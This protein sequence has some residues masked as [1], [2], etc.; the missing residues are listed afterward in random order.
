MNKPYYLDT[1]GAFVIEEYQQAKLFAD[2]FPGVSG[3]YG[4]PMWAFFVNRG[5]AVSSFG[6]ESKDKA[7]LEF[8]PANKAYRSTSIEGFRT[9]LKINDGKGQKYYEPF[10]NAFASRYKVRQRM[11]ITSYD[12]TIEE[13]NTTLGLKVTV[14]YFTM[15]Q[16]PFAGLV[17]RVI[18]E[19]TGPK[20]LDIHC[21]DG[22]PVINPYGLKD[23]LSKNMSRTVE[24]W[25]T[26]HHTDNKAPF[27]QLKVEV[28]DTPQV[29]PIKEGNFYF[30]FDSNSRKQL[31]MIV[32]ASCVFGQASDFLVPENFLRQN[33]FSIPAHQQTANRTPSAM[34]VNRFTL[35]KGKKHGFTALAGFAH[36]LAELKRV[37]KKSTADG[38]IEKKAGLNRQIIDS[39]KDHCFTHSASNE[40][41]Q[42]CGQTFLD[43]I[44]R[45][46]LPISLQNAEGAVS[47]N[48]Y[49]RKHGDL[50]R[51][52]NFF[53]LSPT[54]LSQGN[55]NYRDVNQNRRND[56][57]FNKDV[58]DSSIVNFLNLIQADGYNPLIV[59]GTHFAIKNE[60][61][62]KP[63]FGEFGVE[64]GAERLES[65]LKKGF[66]P[67]E[68]LETVLREVPIKGKP[69]DFLTKI[70]GACT[71]D[72]SA[73][74]GEGFWSDH[75][76]YNLDL[77]NSYLGLY[78]EKLKG[79]FFE[80]RVFT[81]FLNDLY[82][83]PRD[84]RY[85]LTPSGV[86]Q[87]HSL[88]EHDKDVQAKAKGYKLRSNN[89]AGDVYTTSLLVK[90]TCLLANKAATLDPSGIGIEM[91]ANK[92]NW[93]DA[94]NGLPGL[95]GS[96]ISETFEVKRFAVF[97]K[98]SLEQLKIDDQTAVL[99]FEE[100]A[101]FIQGLLHVLSTENDPFK[102]WQKSNDLKEHYRQTVRYGI[103]GQEKPISVAEI[104]KLM[105]SIIEK[106]DAGILKARHGNGLFATYFYH[107][108]TVYD[109]LDKSHYGRH[110]VRANA[111]KRHDLPLFLEG[112][113]H[114]L[115][116][117]KVP[118]EAKALYKKV[119]SSPLFDQ[120]LGMYRVNADLSRE[121]DEI[122]RT[123]IF[124]AGW[125]ENGSVW[126]HMEYKY[127]LE[128]L[129]CGLS[130]EFYSEIHQAMVPF[131]DP[132]KYGRSIL[133]NS[134]FIVS[135]A[136]E[137]KDLHGRGFVA[138]L[139]G[140][141]AEF[142]HIWLV[143]NMGLEPFALDK[144][145]RLTLTFDPILPSWL[146]TERPSGPFKARTYSFKLFVNIM[147]TYHNPLLKD[148][149]GP[150]GARAHKIILSY[151]GRKS[152]EITG[153]V[154]G[155][156]QALDVRNGKVER[157]DV[158]LN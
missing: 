101:D 123:R 106:C 2:F 77:I 75:W 107:E 14:N 71:K 65:I 43:N 20:K 97:V 15:P 31:N 96:S 120:K 30:A 126:L 102:Y 27:Y 137:D 111:F 48:V 21:V 134:S 100:L 113:V 73:E 10:A 28:A 22:L 109:E 50:E 98:S 149:F 99:V 74:A 5:Q 103:K 86:R 141:T 9:F 128:L 146:F 89:G 104:K 62:I 1:D 52:Y 57:W 93:Y 38:F 129:R 155:E 64:K 154:L 84:S 46:G 32:E 3:L 83:L 158:Y 11:L 67:G 78:P 110:H 54:F 12:L 61:A 82:V 139:S 87:F 131:M 76:T 121:S 152:V 63:I 153:R 58:K 90:L 117:E 72:E 33:N 112:F 81:F 37:V 138:R 60:A 29:T 130:H 151:P 156:I 51:D 142:L 135:S 108:V 42:Y 119:R 157:I 91:E 24:A 69:E 85:I 34:S 39:I 80:K 144:Q 136:H 95:L 55:G 23:W 16:E 88:A 124:P 132:A 122:G 44:L 13:I 127:F 125:L 145:G 6:I 105:G 92:P 56:G 140:S 94:L 59:K 114:A 49:S 116:N 8:Q 53:I 47:F 19:N 147:V 25:M 45:G 143:M 40:F 150:N 41:N 133:Q 68:L 4:I 66:M 115:R 17:R 7:I 79:L 35:G 36:D 70:L 148:T 18:I 118:L 26:V